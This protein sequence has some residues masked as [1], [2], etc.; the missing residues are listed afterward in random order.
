MLSALV[1]STTM[2]LF[3]VLTLAAAANAQYFSDGWRPGQAVTAEP[4]SPRATGG[5]PPPKSEPAEPFSFSDL[6]DF[7]KVL[8]S[9]PVKGMFDKFGVNITERIEAAGVSPWDDR[10]PLITDENYVD[11]VVNEKMTEEEER[12]RVWVIVMYVRRRR[13]FCP[14]SHSTRRSASSNRQEGISK[15]VDQ[16]VDETYNETL[17]AGDLP[18]VRFGRIDYL[19]V[20]YVTTKWNLW[21]CVSPVI[22][23]M[24]RLLTPHPQCPRHCHP[25][26]PRS[27]ATVLSPEPAAHG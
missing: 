9:G 21:K 3:S 22:C 20:T 23:Y 18:H 25:Q 2:K 12:D 19:N 10:I 4:A 6:L 26:G 15:F 16:I 24:R 17:I 7:N 1:P 5:I 8:T 14:D 27:D 11:V 13:S